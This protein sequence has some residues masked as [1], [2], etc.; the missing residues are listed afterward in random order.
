MRWNV[1][2]DETIRGFNVY[3]RTG[4]GDSDVRLTT[5]GLIAPQERRF[6]DTDAEPGR[7]YLYTLGVM[8][9]DGSEVMS[10]TVQVTP[11]VHQLA[12]R[13]NYPNPF[14]PVTTLAFSLPETMPVRL[15][16][17]DA[18][19]TRV[20]TIVDGIVGEGIR[21]FVWDGRNETGQAVG[22]GVYFCR[23]TAGN[24]TLTRKTVLIR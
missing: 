19:G 12:L 13:Q 7:L 6:V 24:R 8:K 9:A 21:E 16:I 23:L 11:K 15:V 18:S 20:K 10:R 17:Y 22:S 5:G 3:R 14:N 4:A 2:A 1:H